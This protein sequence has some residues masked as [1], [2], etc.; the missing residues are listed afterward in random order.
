MCLPTVRL[1]WLR[2]TLSVSLPPDSARP[3]LVEVSEEVGR[4]CI[5]A[6]RACSDP[7]R[8]RTE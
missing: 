2:S 3:H 1:G 8:L 5:D 6:V 7:E 4:V